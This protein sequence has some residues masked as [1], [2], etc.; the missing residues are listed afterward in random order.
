M[1]GTTLDTKTIFDTYR[2]AFASALKAQ[3]EG[4]KTLE[5]V[6]RYQYALAGDYLEWSFA[7]AK[8]ALE[9]KTP[10]ELA[11]KQ[12]ELSKAFNEKLGA[13]VQEFLTL[14]SDAQTRFNQT[15]SEATAKVAPETRKAA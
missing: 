13:R 8:A 4:V 11:P 6:G 2:N 3:Q 9:A 12:L 10:A 15:V 1:S 14:A 5:Q 7:Q